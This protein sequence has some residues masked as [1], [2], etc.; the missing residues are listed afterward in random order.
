M[1]GAIAA[2]I[3]RIAGSAAAKG[4]A[5]VT[6]KATTTKVGKNVFKRAILK[7]RRIKSQT[8][9][10]NK[11]RYKKNVEDRKRKQKEAMLEKVPSKPG[12]AG[13]AANAPGMSFLERILNFIGTLLVGW[14]VNNLPKIIEFVQN[15]IIRIKNIIGTLKNFITN[16]TNWFVGIGKVISS[17][18]EN[19]L[20]LDFTDSSGKVS[21]AMKELTDSFGAMKKDIEDGKKHLTTPLGQGAGESSSAQTLSGYGESASQGSGG[22]AGGAV[23]A[24]NAMSVVSSMGFSKQDWDLYRNTVAKI[25]SGGNYKAKGGS[26]GHYDGRYQL[27]AAAK[28]DGA[29]Y[30]GI[31]DPG[32]D[33]SSREAFR[34]NP[35]LQETLFAGF[36]KANHTY[37]M[38][39]P[40]YRNASPQ[41]KLQV[42]G[43]A[44]N[45]GM[46]GA[47]N[48]LN[49][50]IVG[51]DGFGTKGTKYTD[52]I[53][54]EFRKR[55]SKSTS[56]NVQSLSSSTST[57]DLTSNNSSSI[58]SSSQTFS[59]A[60]QSVQI[61]S[62]KSSAIE[63][64]A[65]SQERVGQQIVIIEE[66]ASPMMSN[67]GSGGGSSPV[68]V[69]GASLNSIMKKQLLTSLAYT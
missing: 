45:Q 61:S 21:N 39:N 43:Y 13:A 48:W 31:A 66:E 10:D 9:V 44:H 5:R 38:G 15:L 22:Q 30:A 67:G 34:N 47:D 27:G 57:P 11:K 42:L 41:R 65:L 68:V 60:P 55:G 1:I 52:A 51:A 59:S 49:T 12:A 14:L 3:G 2:G 36:T 7:R 19:F 18:F 69:M 25:E 6:V 50:G 58:S 17:A 64:R 24:G 53:A 23:E 16:V 8:F 33:A 35:Q 46:G 62:N 40:K 56:S 37:L 54:A 4:A 28:T 63:S 29:R 20:N 32:H 26:G